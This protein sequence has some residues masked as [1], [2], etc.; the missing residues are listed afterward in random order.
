MT[1]RDGWRERLICP[2]CGATGSVVP[3]QANPASQAYHA[4]DENVRVE[5]VPTEFRAVVTDLGCQFY[6]TSC[7]ALAVHMARP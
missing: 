5:A 1:E 6:C 2:N 4:G 7:G 3:S